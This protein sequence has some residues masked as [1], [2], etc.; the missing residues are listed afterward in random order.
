MIETVLR[1]EES[2]FVWIDVTD[3]SREELDELAE[4]YGLHSTSVQDC[5]DPEHL[6]KHERIGPVVF[7][8]VRSYD[9]AAPGTA[10]STRDLTRKLAIFAGDGFVLSIHRKPQP[11]LTE[12]KHR[13][14]AALP[15]EDAAYSLLPL[16]IVSAVETFWQPL[17]EAEEAVGKHEETIFASRD[18]RRV[19]REVYLLKRRVTVIRWMARH[20]MEVIQRLRSPERS[21]PLL[22]DAREEAESLYFAADELL[23][24]VNSLLNMQLSLS[25]HQTNHVIRILTLFSVFFMPLTFIVGVYGMNFEHMP[26][27]KW[28]FGYAGAWGV[29]IATTVGIY[30]WFRRKGWLK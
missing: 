8:I 24:D 21:A 1:A 13:L 7:V 6:P 9:E 23:E 26:E 22:Q 11:Y 5:L 30:T 12:I 20:T 17:E 29:M 10:E 25:A 2:S 27:L 28:R 4:R 19:V 18:V 3:P 14:P 15:A 16:L